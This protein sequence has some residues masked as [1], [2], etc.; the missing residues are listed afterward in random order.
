M[1]YPVDNPILSC[2]LL[3]SDKGLRKKIKF[4]FVLVFKDTMI[5][6]LDDNW[7]TQVGY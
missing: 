2:W 1:K 6:Y 5:T 7:V 4:F 3:P